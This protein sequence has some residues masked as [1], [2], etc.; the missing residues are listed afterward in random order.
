[1]RTSILSAALLAAL[2]VTTWSPNRAEAQV[3]VYPQVYSSP[4]VYSSSAYPAYT[5][6]S[7]NYSYGWTNPYYS[8]Y[9]SAWSN[10]YNYGTWTWYNTTPYYTGYQYLG[11]Y[12][13]GRYYR[14]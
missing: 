8:T 4:V 3:L 9:S 6:P 10:P 11:P 13:W 7:Y 12:R 14:W 2:A 5:Y 1:M